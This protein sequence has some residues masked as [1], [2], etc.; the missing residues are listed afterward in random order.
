MTV[1]LARVSDVQ[2][3]FS[4][5]FVTTTG[6]LRVRSSL[7]SESDIHAGSRTSFC[8]WVKG[9]SKS[10]SEA[11]SQFASYKLFACHEVGRVDRGAKFNNVR[12]CV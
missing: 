11:G 8:T 7:L 4:S 2:L 10:Y 9:V 5:F 3:K 12:E 6:G 1:E